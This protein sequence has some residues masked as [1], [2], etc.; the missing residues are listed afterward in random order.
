MSELHDLSA[1][2]LLA[3]YRSKA[4]SPVEVTR[5]V[6]DHVGG[7]EPHLHATYAFE[8]DAALRRPRLRRRAG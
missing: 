2:E 3:A 1:G 8:P 6:V 5:A 4:L 7:W